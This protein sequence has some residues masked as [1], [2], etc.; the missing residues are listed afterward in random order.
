MRIDREGPCKMYSLVRTGSN[1]KMTLFETNH[2]A[3]A[4]YI[5]H[6]LFKLS[7]EFPEVQGIVAEV[8]TK[9]SIQSE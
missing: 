7:K 9:T 1:G 5:H 2:R 4:L 6:F 8:E 3:L